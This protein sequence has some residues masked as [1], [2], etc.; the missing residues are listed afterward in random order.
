MVDKNAPQ[1]PPSQKDSD[2]DGLP[3]STEDH[4][5]R[6]QGENKNEVTDR[7]PPPPPKK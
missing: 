4:S 2:Q 5:S 1:Q 6:S 3:K 7:D